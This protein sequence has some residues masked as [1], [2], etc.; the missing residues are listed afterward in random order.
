MKRIFSKK[1][2]GDKETSRQTS[3]S[4]P[5]PAP[6]LQYFTYSDVVEANEPRMG[7]YPQHG[8][9]V[10]FNAED[11][12]EAKEA[13]AAAR[14][15]HSRRMSESV[16]A[17]HGH[18]DIFANAPEE[19]LAPEG[20]S[21]RSREASRRQSRRTSR[22]GSIDGYAGPSGSSRDSR[23][24][25][26]ERPYANGSTSRTGRDSAA[27]RVSRPVSEIVEPRVTKATPETAYVAPQPQQPLASNPTIAETA[28]SG[29]P[30]KITNGDPHSATTSPVQSQTLSQIPTH[31]DALSR[32]QT[33]NTTG[34]PMPEPSVP[35]SRQSTRAVEEQSQRTSRRMSQETTKTNK[36]NKSKASKRGSKRQ[37]KPGPLKYFTYDD[38]IAGEPPI[39]GQE[40]PLAEGDRNSKAIKGKGRDEELDEGA[41]TPR[42]P[43]D[44]PQVP[45]LPQR[46][47]Q[48]DMGGMFRASQHVEKG[49][50]LTLA[51]LSRRS[52]K[53]PATQRVASPALS[54]QAPRAVE[55]TTAPPA[56]ERTKA[57]SA[58]H[59]LDFSDIPG[60][61]RAPPVNMSN[62]PASKQPS[63]QPS[64]EFARGSTSSPLASAG[65]VAAATTAAGAGA[66]AIMSK[67]SRN[68]A[69]AVQTSTDAAQ[70]NESRPIAP[71]A[72]QTQP[73]AAQSQLQQ[74]PTL[75]QATQRETFLPKTAPAAAAAAVAAQ[76]QSVPPVS[77]LE[78]QPVGQPV[79]ER[80]RNAINEAPAPAPI[81]SATGAVTPRP[82]RTPRRVAPPPPKEPAPQATMGAPAPIA[83]SAANNDGAFVS[84]PSS[85]APETSAR[86]F[87]APPSSSAAV[88]TAA[89][90]IEKSKYNSADTSITETIAPAVTHE[91]VYK[92]VKH[93][94]EERIT[95]EIHTYDIFHRV[96][97]IIDVE[98]LS[99]RHFF[100][101]HEGALIEVAEKDIPGRD[102]AKP[103][104]TIMPQSGNSASRAALLEGRQ[105]ALGMSQMG[106]PREETKS[107]MHPD[108][109]PVT[110]TTHIHPPTLY[111]GGAAS[112]QSV[113]FHFDHASGKAGFLPPGVPQPS[114]TRT[115][116]NSITKGGESET[117]SAVDSATQNMSRVSLQ[118]AKQVPLTS[119]NGATQ[120]LGVASRGSMPS[121]EHLSSQHI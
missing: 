107:W 121:T 76:K 28:A 88:P 11:E 49:S 6:G 66:A 114:V 83:A 112:G 5:K 52:T 60:G 51:G 102:T 118:D 110:E 12:T 96:Q 30:L 62:K 69:K 39:F 17:G 91:T 21:R 42:T 15:R 24:I 72:T 117:S 1:E 56:A 106:G 46:L 57:L 20:P 98:V 48:M 36:T 7:A 115:R 71:A 40:P 85:P 27:G 108:G 97:P 113:P 101:T 84:A 25:S 34:S 43:V 26:P 47:S 58:S 8:D 3:V 29:R 18:Q 2:K 63:K 119:H 4:K 95:R 9:T 74:A 68:D 19:P 86:G 45:E 33:V 14:S 54:G 38:V 120:M 78:G 59:G 94:R 109:Y 93:V 82:A 37:S 31:S 35:P 44:P 64:R 87:P 55:T 73:S 100:R 61:R 22:Q 50:L 16:D 10:A 116:G 89:Q 104:W 81:A 79:I 75:A 70:S 13:L 103:N 53:D 111:D 99:A 67:S 23:A 32:V 41:A 92:H 105:S 65:A 77:E 80:T 90:I